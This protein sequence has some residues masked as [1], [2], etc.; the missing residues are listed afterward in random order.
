M[1]G[2]ISK[3]NKSLSSW[4]LAFKTTGR[5]F[6]YVGTL[7]WSLKGTGFPATKAWS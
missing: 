5:V 4:L 3:T 7:V 1:Q 6:G 2:K